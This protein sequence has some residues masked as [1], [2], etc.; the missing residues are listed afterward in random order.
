MKPT[1][2]WVLP[3]P[4]KCKYKGGFPLHFEKKLWR[5]L[6]EP[7]K[8]L[9]PFGG[10]SEIGD[11]VDLNKEVN[12]TFLGDAHNLDFIKNNTYDLVIVDPPYDNE[13]AKKL[14]KTP[15]LKYSTYVKEAVRVCRVGGR[16]A[17]YHWV[18]TPRPD[19]T[20]LE[21][22]IVIL[23]RVWHRPRVCQIFIKRGE[24]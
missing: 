18:M 7:K 21:R 10:M 5:I 12:P 22:R 19:F 14:Y 8:V 16:I 1:E 9:H 2:T 6:G 17:V 20:E 24:R 15:K 11:R 13:Q 23:T 4:R 3:R